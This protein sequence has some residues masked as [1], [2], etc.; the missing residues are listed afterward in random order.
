[1][2]I[3][4]ILTQVLNLF[5]VDELN[6]LDKYAFVCLRIAEDSQIIGA[7]GHGELTLVR[8]AGVPDDEFNCGARAWH[9]LAAWQCLLPMDQVARIMLLDSCSSAE[10]RLSHMGHICPLC[11]LICRNIVSIWMVF[12]D[13]FLAT[14]TS[15]AIMLRF[16]PRQERVGSPEEV[17]MTVV[18]LWSSATGRAVFSSLAGDLLSGW[19]AH[20]ITIMRAYGSDR[21]SSKN[22]K[23]QLEWPLHF[24]GSSPQFLSATISGAS[25]PPTSNK[26]E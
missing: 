25:I 20:V 4:M 13:C 6:P 19:L 21:H 5:S 1:M 24:F 11:V 9:C 10:P 8:P 22:F 23:H 18:D 16:S 7:D 3:S 2:T 17:V 12:H 15:S 14:N 26:V